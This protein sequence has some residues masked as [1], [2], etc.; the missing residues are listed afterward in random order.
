MSSLSDRMAPPSR[1]GSIPFRAHL[2][3]HRPTYRPPLRRSSATK[4]QTRHILLRRLP[5]P[6]AIVLRHCCATRK[7]YIGRTP[8]KQ[9]EQVPDNSRNFVGWIGSFSLL[10]TKRSSRCYPASARRA[11]RSHLH[12]PLG[13]LS[14]YLHFLALDPLVIIIS[15]SRVMVCINGHSTSHFGRPSERLPL[16]PS[17]LPSPPSEFRLSP[18]DFP[19]DTESRES[20]P[21]SA[22]LLPR[23]NGAALRSA[24]HHVDELKRSSAAQS[25]QEPNEIDE[26]LGTFL[27]R[28]VNYC[29]S[30]CLRNIFRLL[31]LFSSFFLCSHGASSAPQPK[32]SFRELVEANK[33]MATAS[34]SASPVPTPSGPTAHRPATVLRKRP[35]SAREAECLRE[36]RT[37]A[38]ATGTAEPKEPKKRAFGS[39]RA[40]QQFIY[41]SRIS[42]WCVPSHTPFLL[43]LSYV[44]VVLYTLSLPPVRS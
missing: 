34:P 13:P 25:A 23:S 41:F 12:V 30:L 10:Q 17:E 22:S 43:S 19:S 3:H 37:P 28:F 1:G 36:E 16:P 7:L 14:L 42:E 6:R 44:L 15:L 4:Y 35:F 20:S 26:E 5:P 9:V 18:S 32:R 2:L 40:P 31:C 11:L 39:F 38:S 29:S 21:L 24:Q 8:L 27:I 33:K